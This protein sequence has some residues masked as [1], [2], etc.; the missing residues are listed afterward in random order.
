M[1]TQA[2]GKMI[3]RMVKM[4]TLLCRWLGLVGCFMTM[5]SL[6]FIPA[7]AIYKYLITPG[8]PEEA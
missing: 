5:S 3:V 2:Q 8:T 1:L 4:V 6:W 7:Y